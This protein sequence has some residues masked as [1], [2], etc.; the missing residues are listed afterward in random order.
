MSET[1]FPHPETTEVLYGNENIQRMVLEAYPLIKEQ[2]GSCMDHTEV[3][4]AVTY[5]AIWNGLLDVKKRGIRIRCIVEATPENIVY[6]RKLIQVAQVRHLTG[7]RSNF[8]IV[9]RKRCLLHT[10]ANEEQPLSHA[11]I[12]NVKGIVDA[13]QY[14]FET[15][16]SKAI[17]IE[18]RIK[19]IEE[20]VVSEFIETLSGNDEI[21]SILAYIDIYNARITDY[22]TYG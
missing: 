18:K 16:W 2:H 22:F 12:T 8:G 1:N 7:V 10:I 15:L 21:H 19:E 14:L 11:I 17:P 5:A 4:M 9:D 6:C 3:A 20:G 13:Q